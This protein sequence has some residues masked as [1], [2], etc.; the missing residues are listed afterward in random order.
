MPVVRW[1]AGMEQLS[2]RRASLFT[3]I[4]GK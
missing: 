4:I 2:M 3:S 1:E